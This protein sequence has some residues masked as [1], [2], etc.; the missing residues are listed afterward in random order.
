MSERLSKLKQIHEDIRKNDEVS[1]ATRKHF[2]KIVRE[3][4]RE[5]DPDDEEIKTATIIRNIL[6]ERRISRVYSLSWFLGVETLF[7]IF[8]GLV[9]VSTFN[10]PI[11][12]FDIISWNIFEVLII[13]IR[14]FCIFTMIALFYPY[15][16][17]I[18]GRAWGI[19]FD[20]MYFSAQKEPG[21]KLEYESF[22]R[23]TPT[24]R[25][26]F[27]FFSGLWT[28]ITAFGL[29]IIGWLF[30]KDILGLSLSVIFLCFYGYVIGTGTPKN[31]RGEMGHFNRE[32]MI[33]KS[34]KKKE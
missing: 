6:F 25:K 13:L 2:W 32:K 8:F 31:S 7:G 5:R 29:G 16:R 33:E 14:F 12:W 9:Y 30:A 11:S 34:W 19:K 27:F 15:G 20:G 1:I 4:K 28:F 22:L 10:I 18:A 3:I 17:L 24:K 21:L 23:A 26:W